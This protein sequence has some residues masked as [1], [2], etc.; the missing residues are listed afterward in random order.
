MAACPLPVIAVVMSLDISHKLRRYSYNSAL[1]YNL[2]MLLAF[3]GTTLFPWW[4]GEQHLTIPLSLGVVAA[5]LTDMDDRFSMRLRNL[6]LTYGCF[7]AAAVAVELLY[8][9][10]WL[11]GIGL[12]IS[13]I[14]FI[15][16]GSLGQ[17]YATI[18]FGGLL[19]AIYTMIG[20]HMYDTWYQQPIL[21]LLGAMWYSLLSLLAY[22]IVPIRQVQDNLARS[23]A[24]LAHVLEAKATLYDPDLDELY[25]QA[26]VE[27]SLANAEL[28]KT[29]N[30]T[31]TSLLSRLKGDRGQR[32]TR[33]GL[34]YYFV[35]Q[36]IHER[37]SSAHVQYQHLSQHFRY[38]DVMFRFQRLLNM[39]AR[40]CQQVAQCILLRQP[41]THSPRFE[42]AFAHLNTTIGRWSKFPQYTLQV[43][44]LQLL[45]K[46]LKAIDGQLSSLQLDPNAAL[47]NIN[48]LDEDN[49]LA[50]EDLHG[51]QDMILRIKQNLSP[52]SALFRHAIR[53]SCVLSLGYLITQ[54]AH[55]EHGAWILLT[56]LFVCQPNYNATKRRLRLRVLGTLAGIGV[57][58]PLIYFVPDVQGKLVLII[59]SGVLFFAFRSRQYA[60]ATMFI[61][62]LV[63]L[64]FSL[65]GNG[66]GFEIALPRIADTLLGCFIA[67]LAVSYIWPDWH[68]RGLKPMIMNSLNA[69]I[70]YMQA[71][72]T[73]YH[74]GRN[75]GLAYR[76]ARRHAHN[77]DSE[78]ASVI[79][80]MSAEP[81]P[82]PELMNHCF[83]YLCLSH[84]LLSYIS[85]LGAH[86][87]QLN[88]P[89]TLTFLDE[90]LHDL[91]RTLLRDEHRHIDPA[92]MLKALRE[93]LE[94][95]NPDSGSKQQ[96]ILQQINL[97]VDILPE[98]S[99]LKQVLVFD[100]EDHHSSELA[101]L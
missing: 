52:Q 11:F 36:D 46:N 83:R 91:Q 32:S 87:E 77:S 17:R 4:L 2:R 37:A 41:Y 63:L 13:S 59:L 3:C 42:Y 47:K 15:L 31:K 6:L 96:L 60:H 14:V 64:S 38:S 57:G 98:L 80:A 25:D 85:A 49:Q 81:Q 89:L 75:H 101:S 30:E 7:F 93:Q 1:M 55:L 95:V 79:S 43:S 35:A 66:S 88:D 48:L 45:Y 26:V 70:S 5:A 71:I 16:L 99:Q 44:A 10:P 51:M 29:L 92:S 21:L 82:D 73:Q 24:Q 65:N 67:W 20:I 86:R 33:R 53:M 27:L 76:V 12:F 69:Q 28:V 97:I 40:A 19:I 62:L 54:L 8:P 61:T 94:R 90:C 56:S 50:D 68:F 100:T 84:S 23:Y 74:D 39:Q 9:H 72:V 22:V 18:A 58:L 34:H 78:L